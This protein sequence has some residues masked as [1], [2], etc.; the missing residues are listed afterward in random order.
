MNRIARTAPHCTTRHHTTTHCNTLRHTAP[1]CITPHRTATH[2]KYCVALQQIEDALQQIEKVD[3]NMSICITLQHTA[4]QQ[5]HCYTLQILPHTAT[6]CNTLQH[7][8]HTAT[9]CT[10]LQHIAPIYST[11]Y[12]QVCITL[13]RNV[14]NCNTLQ[15]TA[16]HHRAR[17]TNTQFTCHT[18]K[19][20]DLTRYQRTSHTHTCHTHTHPSHTNNYSS[21]LSHTHTSPN[22]S[23]TQMPHTHTQTIYVPFHAHTHTH[24][25]QGH[26]SR[27]EWVEWQGR[28]SQ[29]VLVK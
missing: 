11:R 18:R 3:G 22:I 19:H 7:R 13:Q 10:T 21:S 26:T 6:H 9:H 1:Q 12:R 2:C 27:C 24:T 23:L 15:Y 28:T 17:I 29:C 4:T 5:T 25:C 20:H 14:P 16:T 8:Q